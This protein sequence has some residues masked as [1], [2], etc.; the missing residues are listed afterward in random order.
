M[1][2]WT[3]GAELGRSRGDA[4]LGPTAG[5]QAGHRR[6]GTTSATD[7]NW[8]TCKSDCK[9]RCPCSAG[10]SSRSS[11]AGPASTRAHGAC[12]HGVR[13]MGVTKCSLCSRTLATLVVSSAASGTTRSHERRQHPYG[14]RQPGARWRCRPGGAS[15]RSAGIVRIRTRVGDRQPRPG[16][17]L[18]LVMVP[19]EPRH[20]GRGKTPRAAQNLAHLLAGRRETAM[21]RTRSTNITISCR[22]M[23]SLG[24]A[25]AADS[26]SAPAAGDV[27]VRNA[28]MAPRSAA[29]SRGGASPSMPLSRNVGW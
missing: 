12:A 3:H 23:A 20:L 9:D 19:L 13:S 14:R 8:L 10:A 4:R 15:G 17:P 5:G 21:E 29:A 18:D 1:A 6:A 25:T 26:E 28:A 24:V 27:P 22:R 16:H 7:C 2:T 11:R